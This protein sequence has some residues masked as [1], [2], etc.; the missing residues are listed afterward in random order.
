MKLG[1]YETLNKE[2]RAYLAGCM[3]SDGCFNIKLKHF[4]S[5]KH[6]HARVAIWQT[7]NMIPSLFAYHFGG[8]V[9]K[10]KRDAPSKDIY[11][12]TVTYRKA[13]NL[14]RELLPYL[15]LK[16]R[17]AEILL[18][19]QENMAV[20][21]YGRAGLPLEKWEYRCQLHREIRCLNKRGKGQN[22]DT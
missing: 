18:E 17:Q 6:H 8:T 2:T 9:K 22:A 15:F 11:A 4:R 13:T 7:S 14:C 1:P 3:D 20:N 5:Y 21:N 16:H 12:W 19:L 10:R